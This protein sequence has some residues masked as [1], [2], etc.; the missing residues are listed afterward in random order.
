[1]VLNSVLNDIPIFYMYV[2]KMHVSVWKK[3]V[4]LQRDFL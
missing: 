3:V 1:M 2:M 4:R